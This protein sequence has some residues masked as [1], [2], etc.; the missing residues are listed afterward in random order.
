VLDE[1]NRSANE[2]SETTNTNLGTIYPDTPA[3]Y[4]LDNDIQVGDRNSHEVNDRPSIDPVLAVE[5][6]RR[7][8]RIIKPRRD[9]NQPEPMSDQRLVSYESYQIQKGDTFYRL[10]KK[11][12]VSQK[13]LM[14]MNP[15]VNA[16]KMRIGMIVSVPRH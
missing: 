9:P 6:R 10:A 1:D 4:D 5:P 11:Y 13:Q 2:T 14:D 8:P 7:R 15:D 16:S 12:N 3:S